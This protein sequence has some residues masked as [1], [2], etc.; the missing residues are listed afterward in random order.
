MRLSCGGAAAVGA[1][2]DGIGERAAARASAAGTGCDGA[3]M[4]PTNEIAGRNRTAPATPAMNSPNK[5]PPRVEPHSGFISQSHLRNPGRDLGP[6]RRGDARVLRL[7]QQPLRLQQPHL[8][9]VELGRRDHA[10]LVRHLRDLRR[11]RAPAPAPSPASS[12]PRPTLRAPS[13]PIR[14]RAARCR[15]RTAGH[16]RPAASATAR[17][18][19]APPRRARANSGT[20]SCDAERVALVVARQQRADRVLL[21]LHVAG[22]RQ[23]RLPFALRQVRLSTRP[24]AAAQ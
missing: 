17:R 10:V 1:R 15:S 21:V 18:R 11:S 7:H 2:P 16:A 19:G 5:S 13:T 9:V 20:L 6:R 4:V 14:A 12:R 24:H 3:S 23:A 22:E 8:R